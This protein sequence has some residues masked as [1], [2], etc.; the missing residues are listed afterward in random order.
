MPRPRKEIK[1]EQ[2]EGLCRIQCTLSEIADIFNCSE[3]T[4]ERWCRREYKMRFADAF[5][6]YSAGGKMSL[7]RIQFKLA[8]KSP[9]MAIWLGKQYLGQR[10]FYP[11]E[12]TGEINDG[13]IDALST[14]AKEDWNEG[15]GV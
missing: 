9:A 1:P 10:E 11:D 12:P 15:G 6:R 14:T 2:F 3:D 8:E 4:V 13:F 7:R 5:K